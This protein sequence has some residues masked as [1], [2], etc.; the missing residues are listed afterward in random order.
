MGITGIINGQNEKPAR[1]GKLG[2]LD[3]V[4]ISRI[5]ATVESDGN[6]KVTYIPAHTN[7]DLAVKHIPLPTS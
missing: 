6:V 7:H 2:K 4:C 3:N 5:Y 1:K